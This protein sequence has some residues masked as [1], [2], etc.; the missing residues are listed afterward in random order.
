MNRW[1]ASLA[2]PALVLACGSALAAD[3][4]ERTLRFSYVQPKDSHMGYGVQK[5]AEVVS[6]K[7]GGKI[8]VKGYSDGT[9][10]GDLQVLSS[11]Q[12][13]TIE[14]TTMPPG[15][16]VGQAKVFGIFDV[17]FLFNDFKEADAVLDGPVG[18][19]FIERLPPGVTGLAYWDHGFRNVSNSRRPVAKVED[20]QGLK[21]RVVQAPLF[22][23][24]FN[25]MGA[26]A[27]PLAFTELYAAMETRAV[28]GQDNPIAA[29]EKNK[30]H[31]VQKHLSTTR[32]VYQPLIVLIGKKAWD[33]MSADER[34]LLTEAA[35]EVA[36]D[37]RKVSRGMEAKAIESVKAHG[38]TVTEVSPQERARMRERIKPVTDKYMKEIGAADPIVGELTTELEAVRAR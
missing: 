17:H 3:I 20:M 28:D 22:I 25:A 6:A 21:L 23:D 18:R 33:S 2:L 27:V 32:H 35:R 4:K 12:G 37:Q 30:F 11:L 16:M 9:L 29:F 8:T 14:M 36:L 31:E 26:N 15:L 13:G 19:K 5:F 10:G 38:V 34:Q 1:I 7:S 24:S